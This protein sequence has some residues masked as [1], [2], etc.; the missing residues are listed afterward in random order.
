MAPSTTEIHMKLVIVGR[1]TVLAF[2]V[3]YVTGISTGD[4]AGAFGKWGLGQLPST[5]RKQHLNPP[6]DTCLSSRTQLR[7]AYP[8]MQQSINL[9]R[10]PCR[11]TPA[12]QSAAVPS[13]G[14]SLCSQPLRS[15]LAPQS[16]QMR[17]QRQCRLQIK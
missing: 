6:R 5:L 10:G 16:R 13:F 3:L 8:N 9:S 17:G 15:G 2:S 14:V 7:V 1:S 4:L 11:A 12:R